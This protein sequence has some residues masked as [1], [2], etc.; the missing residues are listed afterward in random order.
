MAWTASEVII[1]EVHLGWRIG[2]GGV[3]V[4]L[5]CCCRSSQRELVRSTIGVGCMSV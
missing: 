3:G 1:S 5:H 2:A 4:V